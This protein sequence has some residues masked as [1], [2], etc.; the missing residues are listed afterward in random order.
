MMSN[1]FTQE[2]IQYVHTL[3]DIIE[4]PDEKNFA[5]K[6]PTLRD[7]D[8]KFKEA[9]LCTAITVSLEP[10]DGAATL[11][12]LSSMEVLKMLDDS[13]DYWRMQKN[14]FENVAEKRLMAECYIDAYQSVR[15]NLFGELKQ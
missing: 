14:A 3:V 13:I 7:L 15:K 8:R 1:N 10:L 9:G 11:P 4:K 5:A 12:L 6:W 2:K